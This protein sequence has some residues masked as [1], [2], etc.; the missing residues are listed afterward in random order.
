MTVDHALSLSGEA[1]IARFG[2]STAQQLIDLIVAAI[3]R[4]DDDEVT[5]LD[6]RLREIEQ[7]PAQGG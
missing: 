4:G 5:A 7:L 1:L 3:R 2:S 6:R